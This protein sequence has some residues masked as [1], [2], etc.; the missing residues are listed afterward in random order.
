LNA[1]ILTK[2]SK[3]QKLEFVS[4]EGE[5]ICV[6]VNGKKAYVSAEYV[7]VTQEFETAL[8]LTEIQYGKGVSDV[9]MELVEYA[10][11]FIGNPYVWG[12]TSLTKGADCSGFVLSVF[13]KFG[14]SLPHY[15]GS[16]AN[17]GK[18][19]TFSELK[20]GDLIFY[21]DEKGK[22]DHV[23]IYAGNGM[24]VHASSPKYGIRTNK[25][26]YR[27]PVRYVNI[28]GD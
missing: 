9:R 19:I 28:L 23:V 20:P 10:K 5:W 27:T 4:D 26:N 17:M 8:T 16:Q 24:V 6:L 15:S 3:N 2:A 7:E 11:K 22:I 1:K 12:G 13:K 25:Y 18:R 14:V 21:A